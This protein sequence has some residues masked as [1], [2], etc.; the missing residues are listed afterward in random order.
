MKRDN[1]NIWIAV[2]AILV[3]ILVINV[4]AFFGRIFQ[5][6]EPITYSES[7]LMYDIADERYFR[8]LE[9]IR[10]NENAPGDYM[11]GFSEY[12]AV[13]DYY[14][15]VS[16]RKAYAAFGDEQEAQKWADKAE[17]SQ[18]GMGDYAFTKEKIDREFGMK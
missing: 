8:L 3:V 4:A 16:L 6:R 2:I 12:K 17:K 11:K 18:N 5:G 1:K 15:A 13:A 14:E 7:S 9:D 10:A